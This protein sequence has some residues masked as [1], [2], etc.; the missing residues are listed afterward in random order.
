[1]PALKTATEQLLTTLQKAA[2]NN[3]DVRV[4]IV[5]F[6]KYVNVGKSNV[7]K[8]WIDWTAG[9]PPMQVRPAARACR[10]AFATMD[11]SGR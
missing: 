2:T 1:M 11:K 4:A 9:T 3:G 5:P 8:S 10:A 6:A 7:N